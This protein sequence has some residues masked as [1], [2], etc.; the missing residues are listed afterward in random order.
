MFRCSM[1]QMYYD[2]KEV[3]KSNGCHVDTCDIIR[4]K[5]SME[6]NAMP[7]GTT[8]VKIRM[9]GTNILLLRNFLVPWHNLSSDA[10]TDLSEGQKVAQTV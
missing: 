5:E 1:L 3:I 7:Y 8:S 2:N 4:Y 10:T 9:L 6:T